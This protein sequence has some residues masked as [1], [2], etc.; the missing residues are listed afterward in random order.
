MKICFHQKARAANMLASDLHIVV[1][2]IYLFFGKILRTYG[3]PM[4]NE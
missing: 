1:Y 4:C 3:T 2:Q